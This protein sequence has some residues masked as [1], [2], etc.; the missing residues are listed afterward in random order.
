MEIKGIIQAGG[1]VSLT[2]CDNLNDLAIDGQSLH[3]AL[4][5]KFALDASDFYI[6]DGEEKELSLRYVV[7]NK[8]PEDKD[9]EF[10]SLTAKVVMETL[11]SSHVSGCYSEWT[12]GKGG[13]DYLVRDEHSIFNELKDSIGKYVH[14]LL[15]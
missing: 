8:V 6:G 1:E 5:K 13:F 4:E 9:I 15:T 7:L 11:Y 3:D 2:C 12:C 14:I 10:E